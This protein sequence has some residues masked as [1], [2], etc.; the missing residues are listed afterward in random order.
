MNGDPL[1][2]RLTPYYKDDSLDPIQDIFQQFEQQANSDSYSSSQSFSGGSDSG[3]DGDHSFDPDMMAYLAQVSAGMGGA[4]GMGIGGQQQAGPFYDASLGLD[5]LVPSPNNSDASSPSYTYSGSSANSNLG[6]NAHSSPPF[7]IASDFLSTAA[8]VPEVLFTS[9]PTSF[10]DTSFQPTPLYSN[11]SAHQL[12]PQQHQPQLRQPQHQQQQQQQPNSY[13]NFTP[14]TSHSLS[15]P[16]SASSSNGAF[17]PGKNGFVHNEAIARMIADAQT[18]GQ[19]QAAQ[20]AYAASYMASLQSQPQ[21]QRAYAGGNGN[22]PYHEGGPVFSTSFTPDFD[23]EERAVGANGG[24]AKKRKT[25][26]TPVVVGGGRGA[27]KHKGQGA[28]KASPLAPNP[29]A[30]PMQLGEDLQ[31]F[32]FEIKPQSIAPRST[33]GLI[34]NAGIQ[35]S[36]DTRK[37]YRGESL[38]LSLRPSRVHADPLLF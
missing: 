10:P 24:G 35:S 14:H 28:R 12:P 17:N 8:P 26:A 13:A 23:G 15:P 22:A 1:P 34:S 27:T 31:A 30:Q 29:Y 2:P 32:N 19:T 25:V 16:S 20:A 11:S 9:F 21:P 3:A 7:S 38:P 36:Q 37:I 33:V 6:N 5:G 18:Q 4:G